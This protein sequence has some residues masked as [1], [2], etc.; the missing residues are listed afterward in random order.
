[1]KPVRNSV[2]MLLLLAGFRSAEAQQPLSPSPVISS[3]H[4]A[5]M[6]S[7]E[8]SLLFGSDDVASVRRAIAVFTGATVSGTDQGSDTAVV[9]VVQSN[10]FVSALVDFGG[11]WTVWANGYRIEPG[12]Q[13][14]GFRV[15]SV[16]ED[17]VEIATDGE[18][19]ARFQLRPYQTWRAMQHD[20]VEGI[21]P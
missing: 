16:K 2:V 6:N 1:M 21:V 11:H 15:L 12:H 7:S 13:P 8:R 5:P 20:V 4:A 17:K 9:K 19:P 18:Q 3:D 10:I 14:P